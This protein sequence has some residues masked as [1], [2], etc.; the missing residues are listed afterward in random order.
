MKA[1]RN[2]ARTLHRDLGCFFAGMTILYAISGIAIN[3]SNVWDPSF[4][5]TE[6]EVTLALPD[7]PSAITEEMIRVELDRLGVGEGYRAFGFP[8]AKRFK[9]YLENGSISGLLGE[10]TAT[11][12]TI[13]RRPLLYEANF[14]HL[15]PP[16]LWRLFADLFAVGLI[17]IVMTG[18]VLPQSRRSL[19]GRGKWLLSAGILAPLATIAL[20][21]WW[22]PS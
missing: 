16:A 15:N 9:I 7:D 13:R 20:L 17:V 10:G 6:E 22:N 3:H 12:E 11:Y 19:A 5:M 14:L 18:L 21:L 2:W 8:S 1:P 4:T